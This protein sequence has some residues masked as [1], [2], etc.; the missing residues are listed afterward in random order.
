MMFNRQKGEKQF[1]KLSCFFVGGGEG[2]RKWNEETLKDVYFLYF[3]GSQ[4]DR[5]ITSVK[6][7]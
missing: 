2:T 3:D 7:P 1:R 6:T 4:R 5:G